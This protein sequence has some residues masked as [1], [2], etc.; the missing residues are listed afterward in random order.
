[1]LLF[2]PSCANTLLI[3]P[4]PSSQLTPDDAH[5]NQAGVHRFQ[6]RTCPYQML[7]DQ[8]FF[9]RKTFENKGVEEVLGGEDSWRNV[10]K[11]EGMYLP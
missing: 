9:E 10:D 6:C 7:L 4:V 2:C 3:T 5:A 8:P 1:M 11:T